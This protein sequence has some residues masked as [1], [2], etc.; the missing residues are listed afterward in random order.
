[1]NPLETYFKDLS[2][3]RSSGAAVDETSYYGPLET[4]FNEIGKTLDS[5]VRCIITIKNR[6]AGNPDGGLFT[7]DQ[8]Q[9]ASETEP[10]PGQI[11]SRGVIEVKPTSDDAW[12][13]ADGEQ[14]SRYLRRY[15]Q[16]LVTNYR[17]F[18]LVGQDAEGNPAKLETYRLA[19]SERELWA[20][21]AHPRKSSGAQN[22]RFTEYLKRVMLYAATLSDPADVAWFLASYARDAK[23]RIEG[24]E[25][26]PLTAVRKALEEALG[27]K[28][29]DRKGE[30]FF[31]STLVQTLFYGLFS[32]WVF[33]SKSHPPTDKTSRFDWRLSAKYLR[34]PVLRKLF[35]EVA[36]P[37]Q[38][39]D[40]NLNEVLDWTGNALNRVDRAS[41]FEKFQEGHAVQYFY[42]PFL[43]AYDPE[44]RKELG[45]WYTPTEIVQYMVAR[46]DAVLQEELNLP[47]GLADPR[48]YVLDPCCG[49]GAYLVEVLKRIAST[50]KSKSGDALLAHDLKR[51]AMERVFGFEILPAPFVVSHLQLGLLLQA[52][53]VPLSERKTERVGVY[54]TNALTGWEPPKGPKTHL[55]FPE[56]EEERDAAEK[57]KRDTPVLVILGNPPYNSFAGVAVDEER[58]LSNAYRT[59]KKAPAPQGQGLN[60]LYVRFYRMAERRIVEKTGKGVVCFISN[61]SWLEGLSFTGLRERYLDA[62]DKIWIDCLNGDKY[63]TGK[64]TPEGEPDPSIF[65]TDM[66]REGIQVGTAI[67]LLVRKAP[68]VPT[69]KVDFRHLWGKTKRQ[70]L[71]ETA[72]Q[73]GKNLYC[74]VAPS[75]VL[76]LPFLPTKVQSVYLP[77]PLLPELFPMSFPGVKTSRDDVVV[78]IDRE[79]LT[80]RMTQYFDPKVSQEEIRK[81]IPGAM[82]SAGRFDAKAVRNALLKRG[83]LPQNIVRYCYRPFDVRWLYWEPE[84]KLLDEKRSEYFPHI[85]KGNLWVEARQKQPMERFD[86]GYFVTVL[87]D[88][89]GN[90]LS[91]YF[92][93][94]LFRSHKQ[95]SLLDAD[96]YRK[97]NLSVEAMSYLARNHASEQKLFY[98]ALSI[99]HAPSYRNENAGA[100]RQD[101]PRVP[102]PKSNTALLSSAE[103]GRKVAAL[104]DTETQAAGVTS[105]TIRPE[106]KAL[107]VLA[108]EGGGPLNPDAGDLTLT[109][110][111]GHTGK[112]GATMPGKGKIVGRE[113]T[114]DELSA[115][116]DGATALGLTEAQALEHLGAS[117]YDVYLNN[118]A[119]WKNVPTKVWDYTIGG[120]QV[121]KKWLSYRESSILNRS[122]TKE[123]AREVMNMARRI[124]ALLLLEPALDKNYQTVK[125][126]TYPWPASGKVGKNKT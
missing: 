117:T 94:Y 68:H 6:G 105:G 57:V 91:S 121:I 38:L 32:A 83:F 108:R 45:V 69:N 116:R 23:A 97:T 1:M 86:R 9:K 22:E 14:V 8:F 41:F 28:F 76:G 25:L 40:L 51:A 31:R 124:A 37:G 75:V 66:N 15:R 59:T 20:L 21:A 17:D 48:V 47:D 103:L 90:G 113:Y 7:Q 106:L 123:E 62:F 36:D 61:Y 110:R 122:L 53:G 5:K 98:H 49:T 44:L 19:A 71:E 30:H 24:V 29:E 46:V 80:K 119:Y 77:W 11:P 54:L 72:I 34:V 79:R 52:L 114:S 82:N 16:V 27:L 88:N 39:E 118:N 13:V 112:G 92:P 55:L 85:Q 43:E 26:P 96:V 81:I 125:Q 35:H 107:A 99:L 67:A 95:K 3:I 120:Y 42:E 78:D 101:W 89:F 102:L 115:T 64:L 109:A 63:K 56:M 74:H 58:E 70:Q 84:T 33:W 4:L 2:T 10:L 60:D 100:L 111:W 87:S 12:V 104:L 73:A 126:A 50:L 65:S 18:V 93:L